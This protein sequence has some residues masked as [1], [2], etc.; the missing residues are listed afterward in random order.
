MNITKLITAS[1]LFLITLVGTVS[2]Q[3]VQAANTCHSLAFA[4]I[5]CNAAHCY[6]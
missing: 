4:L 3:S 1:A 2:A 5:T 6:G